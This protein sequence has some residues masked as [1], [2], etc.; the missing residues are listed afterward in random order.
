MQP[1]R[2][3]RA[4]QLKENQNLSRNLERSFNKNATQ[5]TDLLLEA[6]D[7]FGSIHKIK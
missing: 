5:G 6:Y 2:Q 7:I 3:E 4:V 1:L